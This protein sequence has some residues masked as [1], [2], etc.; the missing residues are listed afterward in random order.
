MRKVE[1]ATQ[2]GEC[3]CADKLRVT[4]PN[5]REAWH[6]EAPEPGPEYCPV[7]G[8]KRENV[9]VLYTENWR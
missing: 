4:W 2:P 5:Y 7:C 1:T 9:T 3:H 6:R 8:G